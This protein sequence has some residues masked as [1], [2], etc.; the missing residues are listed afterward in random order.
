MCLNP[1][2]D[3]WAYWSAAVRKVTKC[4]NKQQLSKD[5]KIMLDTTL[6]FD[7]AAMRP[8]GREVMDVTDSE[9]Q[10]QVSSADVVRI[11]FN[12]YGTL[13]CRA[14][15]SSCVLN[16]VPPKE[17]RMQHLFVTGPALDAVVDAEERAERA[18]LKVNKKLR[19]LNA[20]HSEL[21]L[22]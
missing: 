5:D 22:N 13:S 11:K 10:V 9:I 14:S 12:G 3:D 8:V 21:P 4:V 17:K 20:R 6:N 1:S 16:N 15:S 18:R 7:F 2:G 19:R